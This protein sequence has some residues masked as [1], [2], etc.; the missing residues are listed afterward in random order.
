MFLSSERVEVLDRAEEL[1]E[2]VTNSE[3][4]FHY[5]QCYTALKKD[6]EAQQLI[7]EFIVAKES[8][9]E[10]QRF[11]KY[12]PDYSAISKKTRE[13]KRKIDLHETIANFKKA[14]KNVQKLLDEISSVI[15]HTVSSSI[16]VPTGNPFFDRGGCSGGCRT[17]G[18]C[19]CSK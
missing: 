7:K 3:A 16:K 11:G 18:A 1:A 13:I 4:A 10:V 5:R 9:E 8:F 12:H 19:G 6:A 2:I 15:G 17:G 14:E